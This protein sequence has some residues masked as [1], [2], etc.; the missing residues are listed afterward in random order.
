MALE[1]AENKKEH[2]EP[3]PPEH[4]IREEIKLTR[5]IGAELL[6]T[7]AEVK[8]AFVAYMDGLLD[9][10]NTDSTDSPDT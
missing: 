9:E 6:S 2:K 5:E 3:L 1:N 7:S 4:Y 8:K 10:R